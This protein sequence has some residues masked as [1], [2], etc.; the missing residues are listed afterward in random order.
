MFTNEFEY[1]STITTILDGSAKWPD[2]ELI[3]DDA[4]VYIRQY[5]DKKNSY[6]L[7]VMTPRMFHELMIAM[8][9]TEG[10]FEVILEKN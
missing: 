5:S 3:I 7:I 8:K 1:D 9:T 6:D 2:V 4:G 10:A